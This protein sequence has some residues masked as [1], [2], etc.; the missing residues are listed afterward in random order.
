[1]PAGPW[2]SLG[3]TAAFCHRRAVPRVA[4]PAEL[5]Q[6]RVLQLLV[7]EAILGRVGALGAG[8]LRGGCTAPSGAHTWKAM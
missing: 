8:V 3:V 6:G 5:P 2:H 1:M 7:E 4:L